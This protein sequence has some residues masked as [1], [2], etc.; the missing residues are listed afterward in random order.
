MNVTYEIISLIFDT[1][2]FRVYGQRHSDIN[3]VTT[4]A[5]KAKDRVLTIE[6]RIR[7]TDVIKTGCGGST[8]KRLTTCVMSRVIKDDLQSAWFMLW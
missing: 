6:Y 4:I 1:I 7:Q 5:S 2:K 3:L 8:N